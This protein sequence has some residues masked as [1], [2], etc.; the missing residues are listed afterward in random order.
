MIVITER[1]ELSNGENFFFSLLIVR[2]CRLCKGLYGPVAC[3][4][5]IIIIMRGRER[6]RGRFF[7][8]FVLGKINDIGRRLIGE[9][10]RVEYLKYNY[11]NIR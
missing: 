8:R 2:G 3:R 9:V 6:E 10:R 1:V 7:V 5:C 11:R 4:W